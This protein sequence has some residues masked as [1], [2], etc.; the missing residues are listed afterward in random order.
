MSVPAGNWA[1]AYCLRAG[2]LDI[3]LEIEC[4][5]PESAR[6]EAEDFWATRLYD[7]VEACA[8]EMGA[9]GERLVRIISAFGRA[10]RGQDPETPA[11]PERPMAEAFGVNS[12]ISPKA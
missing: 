3:A 5:S 2:D 7:R 8:D 6:R 4:P 1:R 11:S 10:H 12:P 9:G